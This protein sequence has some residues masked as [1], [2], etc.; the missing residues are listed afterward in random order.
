MSLKTQP[1]VVPKFLPRSLDIVAKATYL[2]CSLSV[3]CVPPPNCPPN[4]TTPS[5]VYLAYAACNE[6]GLPVD[7]NTV[8]YNPPASA[9]LTP[10]SSTIVVLVQKRP[11]IVGSITV[12]ITATI[13]GADITSHTT[14]G[15][16]PIDPNS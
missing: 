13:N 4:P 10:G 15:S 16:H 3:E 11:N 9:P 6:A 14:V 1:G 5:T 2:Q 12:N 8:L 7:P